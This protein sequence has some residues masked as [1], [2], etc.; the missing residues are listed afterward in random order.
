MTQNGERCYVAQVDI[1]ANV[2]AGI[3]TVGSD[4]HPAIIMAECSDSTVETDFP[5]SEVEEVPL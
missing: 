1:S 5:W 2:M 3:L 4:P